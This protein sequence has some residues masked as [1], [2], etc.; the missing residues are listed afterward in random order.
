MSQ[1]STV[2]FELT[3]TLPDTL[4]REAVARGLLTARGLET[5]LRAEL[6][7]QRIDSLFTAVDRLASV[8]L[9]PLSEAEIEAEIAAVRAAKRDV[10]ANRG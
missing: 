5:L 8:Q 3:L 7:R 2:Q 10:H 1:E 6:Q 9:A 4:A